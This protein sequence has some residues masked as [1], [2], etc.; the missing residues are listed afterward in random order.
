[1]TEDKTCNQNVEEFFCLQKSSQKMVHHDLYTP[2]TWPAA[3]RAPPTAVSTA[4]LTA[5]STA[6]G[7]KSDCNMRAQSA[8]VSLSPVFWLF[9]GVSAKSENMET[10][11]PP[12]SSS[13]IEHLAASQTSSLSAP[14]AVVAAASHTPL[15]AS[16]S[17]LRT[18][19]HP[20]K[21]SLTN[22]ELENTN[23]HITAQEQ[24]GVPL[25]FRP[26]IQREGEFVCGW[27]AAFINI[28]ITFPLNKIMFRQQLHGISG[29]RAINQ[30]RKDGPR[31]LYRG[32][33]PP[34]LQKSSS[35]SV[36][37]GMYYKFQ[38]FFNDRLPKMNIYMN[39]TLAAIGAG[40]VEAVFTP[41]ERIQALMQSREYHNK[42]SNTLDA[43]YNLRSYGL[44]EYYRG[45]TAIIC[46]NGPS[47]VAF[48]LGREYLQHLSPQVQSPGEKM[49]LDFISGACLGAVISTVFFPVNVVKIRMQCVLGGPYTSM[50][51]TLRTVVTERNGLTGLYK[52]VH[53]NYMRSFISWGIINASYEF[54]M[55]M[56]FMNE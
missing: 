30:L 55:K 15:L 50:L 53:L 7:Y 13:M 49:A 17:S 8:N 3:S 24:I 33:L 35:L 37:F 2:T 47:N 52:G 28:C 25:H 5:A 41:F 11:I 32:L 18:G 6:H 54:L 38:D 12:V 48:F 34:L 14:S 45:L 9:R 20:R 44:R 26:H 40:T 43:F 16:K 19:A 4:P 42:F 22:L 36:M 10:T 21:E 29:L 1:M 27:G 46:R 56:F 31:F 23:L 39:H 51:T